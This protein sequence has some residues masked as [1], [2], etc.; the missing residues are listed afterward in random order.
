MTKSTL[1]LLILTCAIY[2][3]ADTS[4]L[5]QVSSKKHM[6]NSS[7]T[8]LCQDEKGVMWFGT[9]DGI[10][11]YDGQNL[12][13]LK[14]RE[15]ENYL[16]GNL[17]D[18]IICSGKDICWIQ[19]YYGLNRLDKRTNHITH[20]NNFQKLFRMCKDKDGTLY[21]LK[22]NN[23]IYYYHKN[24]SFMKLDIMGIPPTDVIDFFVDSRD[25]IWIILKD[26]SYCYS[27]HKDEKTGNSSLRFCKNN[28]IYNSSLL[29]SFHQDDSIYFIDEKYNLFDFDIA[30]GKTHYIY[31]LKEEIQ[32]R[33]KISSIINYHGNF[34]I[35]FLMDGLLLLEKNKTSKV[36]ELKEKGI[37]CGVFCLA[38][39]SFQ[40]I[41]WIGTDGQGVYIYSNVQSPIKSTVLNTS[42]Y[43]INRQVRTLFWDKERSLWLGLKGEGIVK[44]H[45]YDINKSLSDCNIEKLTTQNSD[46]QSDAVY[47]FAKSQR[48]ILWIGNEEGLSY[49]SYK[50]GRIKRV[51][52]HIDGIDFK[53]IHSVYESKNA[54]IWLSSVGLGILKAQIRWN[55]DTPILVNPQRYTI[56][57]E[58]FESNYFFTIYPEKGSDILLGN[59]GYGV[60]K[61][62]AKTNALEPLPTGHYK[63]MAM[64]N[65]LAINKDKQN[66]YLIGTSFGLIKYSPSGG[67]QL[68]NEKAGITNN[69]IHGIL[70]DSGDNFWLSTNIGLVKFNSRNNTL[71]SYGIADGMDVVE[72]SDGA[73]YKDE[74]TGVLF[75]GGING[76]ITIQTSVPQ[77]HIYMPPIHLNE[78]SIFGKEQYLGD[79]IKEKNGND[80]ISLKYNQNFFSLAFT[81]T[82]YLNGNNRTYYYK[83]KGLS[84][85]WINNGTDNEIAFTNMAPGK[86]TLL[87]KYH[88][89]V[90]DKESD[91]YSIQIE[92][93][94]PWY[95]S[96]IAYFVYILIIFII[97][98]TVV[99]Y[100]IIKSKNKKQKML[101][102]LELKH[103]KD[104]FESKLQFF[105]NIA[106]EFY[107]P[108]TLIYGPCKRILSFGNITEYVKDYVRIIQINA[109]R[110]NNLVEELIEFRRIETGQR[111]PRIEKTSISELCSDISRAFTDLAKSRGI[112]LSVDVPSSIT[113]NTDYGF[114]STIMTNLISYAFNCSPDGKTV[115]ISI[116]TKANVLE[117]SIANEGKIDD[118]TSKLLFNHRAV[119]SEF[120]ENKDKHIKDGLSLPIAY[121]IAKLLNGDLKLENT[122]NGW[123]LFE[124]TLPEMKLE[125]ERNDY[126]TI[127]PIYTPKIQKQAIMKLPEYPFD[128][129]KPSLLII[130]EEIEMLWFIGETFVEKFNII[131]LQD[132]LKTD[133]ILNKILP[134][135]IIF[136]VTKS[137]DK[138]IELTKKL[139][140]RKETAHIPL[141]IISGQ[142]EKEEQVAFLSVGA[143]I[144]ITQPFNPE[145]LRVSVNQLLERKEV[146]KDYFHS[147]IS[148]FERTEGRLTHKESK[149]FLQ[150]ILNIISENLRNPELSPRFIAE[151]F[152][153]STRSLYRKMEEIGDSTPTDLIRECRLHVAEDLLLTTKK[154]IDEIV[155]EAGFANKVTFFKVFREK[156]DCTPKKYRMMHLKD[157]QV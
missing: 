59:K 132:S 14:T 60:Y 118:E 85:D 96:S 54:E 81:S 129:Q 18:K 43:K 71:R 37:N 143:E 58:D 103:Q 113:W 24:G 91:I 73:A 30:T 64:N 70:H 47:C 95:T 20:Y 106:H 4:N 22:D 49:Y 114:L 98:G 142:H 36:Y 12:K 136:D 148:S 149:L 94:N 78:L 117:I 38:K 125:D 99:R 6:T 110:L 152:A 93:T 83:L 102:D 97:S 139:K 65:I 34:F 126:K 27:I 74:S 72:F 15:N 144:Y 48:N 156:Y 19:T 35:G 135:L 112:L 155:F 21:I 17:I 39:D 51:L 5:R 145:Y 40:D 87:V 82:D 122:P 56:N 150:S 119:L 46:L 134:V 75:F 140:S 111:S 109:E 108:L 92:I 138:G 29:Y 42:E 31:S 153:I 3:K 10:N 157:I 61:F 52:L 69:T 123:M 63:Y 115:K 107:T 121:N 86:Y 25:I 57:H 77:T 147:P 23:S 67:V 53:Y 154:T 89:N 16:S 55:G 128:E 131:P 79:Y 50:E 26:Y 62:N 100:Y 41:V 44:I 124:L 116:Q 76:F 90:Y 1:L 105:T 2:A 28:L 84:K 8:S 80:F 45:N 130:D 101:T 88:N 11:I 127:K 32:K 151:K 33:G 137:K 146:L 141:I 104:I 7:V 133:E 66:N 9:C 120:E 68:F 13:N